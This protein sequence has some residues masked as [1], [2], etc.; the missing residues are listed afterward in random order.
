[1]TRSNLALMA[2]TAVLSSGLTVAGVQ[3]AQPD[4]ASAG[5]ATDRQMLSELKKLNST[6]GSI[7]RPNSVVGLLFDTKNGVLQ[8][9]CRNT[10]P[11]GSFPEC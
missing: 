11:E 7:G 5:A 9:I 1:M 2:T 8:D 10:R 4:A 6:L 3:I